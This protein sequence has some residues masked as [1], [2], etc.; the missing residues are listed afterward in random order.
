MKL[1]ANKLK[2]SA[3]KKK[4]YKEKNQIEI[5]EVKNTIIKITGSVGGLA[6]EWRGQG[7]ISE[8]EHRTIDITQSDQQRESR[9]KKNDKQSHR[10]LRDCNKR[11]VFCIIRVLQG[12]EKGH[13][14]D[15]LVKEIMTKTFQIWQYLKI[16]QAEKTKNRVKPNKSMQKSIII[17]LLKIKTKEKT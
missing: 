14:A 10:D 9:L 13:R 1:S 3:K 15:K 17:T 5:L 12:E 11:Y 4:I 7:R 8:L 16:Q 6:A 2:L